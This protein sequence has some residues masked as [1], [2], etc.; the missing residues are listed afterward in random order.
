MGGLTSALAKAQLLEFIDL[1]HVVRCRRRAADLPSS[2]CGGARRVV[3]AHVLWLLR[4]TSFEMSERSSIP[5][6]HRRFAVQESKGDPKAARSLSA[7][8]TKPSDGAASE[9]TISTV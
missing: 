8:A 3:G 9:V 7:A 6:R 4:R 5:A 1:L 2:C